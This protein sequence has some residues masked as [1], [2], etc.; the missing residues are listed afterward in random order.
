MGH[1][2]LTSNWV[3]IKDK[4]PVKNSLLQLLLATLPVLNSLE[5]IVQHTAFK[6][7]ICFMDVLLAVK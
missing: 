4:R 6:N 1:I 7:L 2:F 3:K 5:V